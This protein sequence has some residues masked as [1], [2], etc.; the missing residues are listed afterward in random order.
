M[1]GKR[2]SWEEIQV[3]CNEKMAG[4]RTKEALKMRQS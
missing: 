3:T 1:E 4:G 2:R